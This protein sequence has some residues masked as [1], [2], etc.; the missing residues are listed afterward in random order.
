MTIKELERILKKELSTNIDLK[1]SGPFFVFD[2]KRG[3]CFIMPDGNLFYWGKKSPIE[4]INLQC[5]ITKEGVK[6]HGKN[7]F[8]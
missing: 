3:K 2:D 5:T 1:K 6:L 4:K 8:K 7:R